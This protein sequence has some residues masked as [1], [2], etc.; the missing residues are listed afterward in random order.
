MSNIQPYSR[1]ML[2]DGQTHYNFNQNPSYEKLFGDLVICENDDLSGAE[3]VK[4]GNQKYSLTKNGVYAPSCLYENLYY[5]LEHYSDMYRKDLEALIVDFAVRMGAKNVLL[6]REEHC[7]S[8]ESKIFDAELKAGISKGINLLNIGASSQRKSATQK[9]SSSRTQEEH[10][11]L[12]YETMTKEELHDW[13]KREGI[14][15]NEIP[16]VLSGHIKR[17]LETGKS[18]GNISKEEE[19]SENIKTNAQL[20]CVLLLALPSMPNFISGAIQ[21]SFRLSSSSE[22]SY[23]S[24]IRYEITF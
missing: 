19:V 1:L 11:D 14:I 6:L 23:L 2:V 21:S 9:E 12:N 10:R 5:P 20:S 22:Y 4:L 3:M 16:S 24:K 7:Q 18:S 15:I 8:F 17:Y 13:I